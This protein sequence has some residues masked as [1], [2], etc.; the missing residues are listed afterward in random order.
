MSLNTA[1]TLIPLD[2][3]SQEYRAARRRYFVALARQ[4]PD[5]LRMHRL[6]QQ[7]VM[8][9]GVIA[10]K[11]VHHCMVELARARV[12]GSLLGLPLW[13]RAA[14]EKAAFLHDSYKAEE[15][16]FLRRHGRTY[17]AYDAA[18]R[19]A[20]QSWEETHMFA[21]LV[22]DI[23]GAVAHESLAKMQYLCGS[24]AGQ[25]FAAV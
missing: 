20:R 2:E 15:I 24:H 4:H 19:H 10:V 12:L 6:N 13:V 14:L 8:V 16:R 5:V 3:T 9:D 22:L 17:Q 18:Q 1:G 21:P 7:F 11:A 25:P 23:A